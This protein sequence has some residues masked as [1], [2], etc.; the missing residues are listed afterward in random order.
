MKKKI[1]ATGMSAAD[2][3]WRL[4]TVALIGGSGT[5]TGIFASESPFFK[6]L[7][8]LAWVAIGLIGAISVALLFYL[9]KS[10]QN[11]TAMAEYTRSVSQPKSRVN[12]LLESFKD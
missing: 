12:P 9:I 8:M 3:A 7:G 6:E 5:L 4:M 11:Q 10:A 2:W 1:F